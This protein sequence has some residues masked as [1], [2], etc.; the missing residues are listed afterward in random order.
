MV[1][2]D[3]AESHHEVV[4]FRGS[5]VLVLVNCLSLLLILQSNIL[6]PLDSDAIEMVC[7]NNDFLLL[8]YDCKVL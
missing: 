3:S 5:C 4:T 7:F 1:V 8:Y 2:M 6:Q